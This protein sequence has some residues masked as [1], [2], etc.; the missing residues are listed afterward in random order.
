LHYSRF[1]FISTIE[2]KLPVQTWCIQLQSISIC[3]IS[4]LQ[5][6][7]KK[8]KE[9][10]MSWKTKIL[11]HER[12]VISFCC[13]ISTSSFCYYLNS[14]QIQH[15]TVILL[16]T[17]YSYIHKCSCLIFFLSYIKKETESLY[18]FHHTWTRTRLSLSTIKESISQIHQIFLFHSQLS[19]LYPET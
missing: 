19:C 13:W 1:D 14:R 12:S 9:K 3:V 5:L 7:K 16:C 11:L 6:L 18:I 8:K 15:W 4:I 17:I 10:K 2:L